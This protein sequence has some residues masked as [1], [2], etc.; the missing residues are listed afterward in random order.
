MLWRDL[1]RFALRG[2]TG[3]R[4][5]SSLSLLGVTI[6]VAAVIV[7]TALGEGARRYVVEQFTSLGTNLVVVIPG[8]TETTGL[9]GFG[10]T[11][12]DL[13]LED[14]R[15]VDRDVRAAERVAP[16]ALGTVTVAHRERRRQVALLGT[17]PEYLPLRELEMGRGRFLPKADL[18]RGAPV[19]V[20]G[21]TTARELFPASDPVG[22]IVRVGEWRMRVIGVLAPMGT[23]LG[24]DMDDVAIAPVA[25]VMR[26]LD[27]RSLFRI[28]IQARSHLELE[29]VRRQA[30]QVLIERHGAEDITVLTQDA[31]VS[32]FG[33]ILST[34]T[35][36]VGAIAA[37]SLSVAGI[38]IMNVMLVAVSER[39]A[40]IGLLKAVGAG[41]RQL[42]GVFLTEAT[43]L[44]GA[45]GVAGIALGWGLTLALVGVFPALPARPPGW[46]VAAAFAV[47]LVTGAVF[48][49]IPAR[50]A[51]RL[52]PARTLGRR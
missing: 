30:R 5:R 8:F 7:L 10:G 6:G 29:A 14:A 25:T 45:G 31:V 51:A 26:L 24:L 20:L 39:A 28:L 36:V 47:A 9:P 4:L 40:E 46:A 38:G 48:G 15:A 17:T 11:P 22:R 18:E 35:M 43:L 34:L 37:I 52:D 50:N 2:L 44:G 32:T 27:R 3:H 12:N 16:L 33:T 1:L 41:R 42:L 21:V 49:L 19:V 23:R 13:T